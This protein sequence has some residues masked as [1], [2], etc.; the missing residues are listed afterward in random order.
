MIF[1]ADNTM[2]I[3]N[4]NF[5]EEY[6]SYYY[7]KD[8]YIFFPLAEAEYEAEVS[9]IN[10]DFEAAVNAPLIVFAIASAIRCKQEKCEE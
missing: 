3:R 8:G 10:E 6:K 5:D 9:A 4:T 2:A 1:Y 7:Y